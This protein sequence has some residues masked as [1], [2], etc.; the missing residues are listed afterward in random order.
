MPYAAYLRIYEPLSA[1]Y[2]PD[3]SRWTAY[4]ASAARPRRLN[5][6]EA[7]HAEA[8]QRLALVPPAIVPD[9]ESEHAY[10]RWADGV[11]Y[12]CPWQTRLRSWLGLGR[13]RATAWPP[14]SQAFSPSQADKA[15]AAYAR[16]C[17]RGHTSRVY[18]QTSAWS[19][20]LAWFVPFA[21][22]ER[23]LAL[24]D[25]P[26]GAA[27]GAGLGSATASV[28][29]TLVYATTMT[30]ARRRAAR[31][32]AAIQAGLRGVFGAREG[33]RRGALRMEAELGEI[34]RWLDEFHPYSLVELDYGGLVH[35]LDDDALRADQSVA[36]I[37]AC[38]SGLAMGESELAM[39]MYQRAMTRREGL[40]A[41]EFAN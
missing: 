19:V 9:S 8:M 35:L 28:T 23:W 4:V 3:L 38:V 30:Q 37:T 21:A 32:T 1:F 2:E 18:I 36:E 10:V 13:L 24:G 41:A 6:L 26:E 27:E 33:L 20:P 40:R 14:L 22:A 34:G 15:M 25:P 5:A 11:T 31:G 12:I 39:A 16:A 17:A 7:E 29:R